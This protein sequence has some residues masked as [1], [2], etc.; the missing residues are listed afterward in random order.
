VPA[1]HGAGL[2]GRE[3]RGN[4]FRR[5]LTAHGRNGGSLPLLQQ[6]D[7]DRLR[8]SRLRAERHDRLRRDLYL[9]IL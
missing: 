9:V 6:L 3:Q 8:L 1:A 4:L 5:R 7:Q 2:P